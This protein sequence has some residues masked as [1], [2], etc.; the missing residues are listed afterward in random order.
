MTYLTNVLNSS[1]STIFFILMIVALGYLIGSIKVK[2]ICLG[3]AGVL[4]VAIIFG[5]LFSKYPTIT[6]N[7]KIFTF[8]NA[9][10]K[11]KYSFL[12][13][14]GT[15][16]FVSAIGLGSGPKFFRSFNKKSLNYIL[17]GLIIIGCG[18]LITILFI[19][20]DKNLDISLAA[21]LMAGALTSTP[22]F[23]AAKEVVNANS[24][25]ITAGY[26]IA[27]LFGVLGVVLFVQ[28]IP[29]VLNINIEEERQR[30]IE[31]SAV[32]IPDIH[33]HTFI[34][35][36]SSNIFAYLLT[37]LL[38]IIIGS[39][40]IPG[41]NFSLGNSGGCLLSGLIIGHYQ[42]IGKLDCRINAR[43]LKFIKELGMIMFMVGTGLPG[44]VSFAENIKLTYFIYG[45]IIT[46]VPMLVGYVVS[47]KV[48]KMSIFNALGSI[49]GGM[50]STPGLGS[51]INVAG[52]DDVAGAYSLTYPIALVFVVLTIKLIM[53]FA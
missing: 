34:R 45:A 16:L 43:F 50:T 19:L 18:T 6:I 22:G 13:S 42:H 5:V 37:V 48:F 49:T 8:F 44:G 25:L 52:S 41:I 32:E 14:L 23:S 46:L 9:D 29:K 24:E 10:I 3:N 4:V 20:L 15:T 28:I 11:A 47:T 35:I 27:Y 2:G 26:G 33:G 1:L 39:F 12:S 31:A 40:Y 36:D 51:L 38:G 30:F 53:M 17:M 7:E 21:G